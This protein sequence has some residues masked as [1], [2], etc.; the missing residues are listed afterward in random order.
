MALNLMGQFVQ[1]IVDPIVFDGI[2]LNAV[3]VLKCD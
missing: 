2:E 1:E 3:Q